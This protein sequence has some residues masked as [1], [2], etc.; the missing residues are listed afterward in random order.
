MASPTSVQPTLLCLGRDDDSRDV[1]DLGATACESSSPRWMAASK[2]VFAVAGV[3]TAVAYYGLERCCFSR[4][5]SSGGQS[6]TSVT[7]IHASM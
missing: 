5:I 4:V 3:G 2:S 6:R 1:P 7:L